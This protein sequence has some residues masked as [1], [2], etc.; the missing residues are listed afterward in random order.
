MTMGI[1]SLTQ[2]AHVYPSSPKHIV[3]SIAVK[4]TFNSLANDPRKIALVYSAL[5]IPVY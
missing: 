2:S 5:L 4:E 3:V 1:F